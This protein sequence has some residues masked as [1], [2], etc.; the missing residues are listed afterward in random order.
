MYPL[1]QQKAAKFDADAAKQATDWIAAVIGEE[2]GDNSNPDGIT[3]AFKDGVKICKLI[4]TLQPGSVKKINES[5]MAFKQV[6]TLQQLTLT[7]KLMLGMLALCS[8]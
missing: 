2:V 8:H 5:K 3:E 7:F 4:N 6:R 1:S